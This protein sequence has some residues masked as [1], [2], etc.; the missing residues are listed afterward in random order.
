MQS[1]SADKT[2]RRVV[3]CVTPGCKCRGTYNDFIEDKF[4]K[5]LK[6]LISNYNVAESMIDCKN[7]IDELKHEK[8]VSAKPLKMSR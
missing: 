8:S 3:C 6:N 5:F 4:L 2:G 1:M 7:Q